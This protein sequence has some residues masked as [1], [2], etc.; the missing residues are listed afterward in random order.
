MIRMNNNKSIILA[1]I[2]LVSLIS[3][4]GMGIHGASAY[5]YGYGYSHYQTG[6]ND[7]TYD[8]Y[9]GNTCWGYMHS[10]VFYDDH[11]QEY[12]DGYTSVVDRYYGVDSSCYDQCG[13]GADNTIQT[14]QPVTTNVNDNNGGNSAY[15]DNGNTD[16][17]QTEQ[18]NA[19]D[20]QTSQNTVSTI[21]SS[22]VINCVIQTPQTV[23]A[24]NDN[25][26][27]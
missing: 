14:Q 3:M 12:R 16:N 25:G 19:A 13:T 26:G 11:S 7:A 10:N 2:A 24:S 1:L 15:S 20:Q 17:S 5:Y 6:I 23:G 4:T 18:T 22:C 9:T 8:C 21:H 27:Y